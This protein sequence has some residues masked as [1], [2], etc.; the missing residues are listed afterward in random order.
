MLIADALRTS[1]AELARTLGLS[2]DALYRKSRIRTRRTQTR[3]REM[4]EI[5]N[6]VEAI[7]GSQLVAYA[8]FRS[9]ALAGFGGATP[10]SLVREG[11][12]DQ[13]HAHLTRIMAGGYA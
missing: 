13:V 8:W 2:P 12:A 1:Q 10:D 5:L 9:E 4:V 11:K 6:R 7:T 3:L